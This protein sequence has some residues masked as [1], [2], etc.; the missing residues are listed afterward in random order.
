MN[1]KHCF[2]F[3]G[4]ALFAALSCSSTPG[5]ATERS[6]LVKV[7]TVTFVNTTGLESHDYLSGSITD[8]T[9]K[10]ME[11]IF[12][13]HQVPVSS[14]AELHT[15]MKRAQANLAVSDLRSEALSLDA[16]LLIYG[17]FKV[18]KGKKG[19]AIEI[20]MHAL[21]SDRGEVIAVLNRQTN[22]SNRIFDDID[23]MTAELVQSIVAYRQK[24]MAES[25]LRD[26]APPKGAKI[27]L[28]RDSI[29]IAP[30]IPPIF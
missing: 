19:D 21:R 20:R 1:M 9:T 8:A 13:Y 16:D 30:F 11:Q 10:T 24:Q 14:T 3:A 25:G 7:A 29:N 22:V 15:R 5:K 17:D 2:I 6:E 23:K 28:T 18:S 27:E 26:V 12:V 4:I